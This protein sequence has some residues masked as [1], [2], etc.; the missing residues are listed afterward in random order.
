MSHYVKIWP[1]S[2]VPICC[3][4]PIQFFKYSKSKLCMVI[5]YMFKSDPSV[6][7][8]LRNESNCKLD[9]ICYKKITRTSVNRWEVPNIRVFHLTY[10]E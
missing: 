3:S 7:Y 4:Q 9:L 2:C 8:I 5:V 10:G 1:A 6:K